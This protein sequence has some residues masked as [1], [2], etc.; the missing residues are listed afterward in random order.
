MS[1]TNIININILLRDLRVIIALN[2]DLLG[3]WG[4]IV[5]FTQTMNDFK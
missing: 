3:F 4:S 2:N 5:G 1:F